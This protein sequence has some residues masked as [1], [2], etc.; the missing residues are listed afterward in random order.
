[1][2]VMITGRK[3]M[4]TEDTPSIRVAE[5]QSHQRIPTSS[6]YKIFKDPMQIS[7]HVQFENF[8]LLGQISDISS[9]DIGCL[10]VWLRL[11]FQDGI[12]YYILIFS[13]CLFCKYFVI[14]YWHKV[15]IILNCIYSFLFRKMIS[16]FQTNWFNII[17]TLF[18][19]LLRNLRHQN[20]RPPCPV[21]MS[22]FSS[23]QP[24]MSLFQFP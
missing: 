9:V 1:M 15:N 24:L 12:V 19:Q 20:L 10:D 13:S 5:S 8:D 7:Q 6:Q 14:S 18:F 21:L 11:L 4:Q 2:S 3:V 22:V 17:V 16:K 23:D